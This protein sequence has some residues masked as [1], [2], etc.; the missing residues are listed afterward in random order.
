MQFTIT[1]PLWVCILDFIA[2]IACAFISS[3]VENS[4]KPNA[5]KKSEYVDRLGCCLIA[6]AIYVPVTALI[7]SFTH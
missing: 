3:K 7:Q 6:V 4:G 5:K 2:A 1:M